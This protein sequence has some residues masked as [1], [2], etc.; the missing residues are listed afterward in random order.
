MNVEPVKDNTLTH[1][2]RSKS[3]AQWVVDHYDN[4]E[5]YKNNTTVQM[6]VKQSKEI[7]ER[8]D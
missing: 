3:T 7:L 4:R 8:K 5:D 2:G 1:H 6:W